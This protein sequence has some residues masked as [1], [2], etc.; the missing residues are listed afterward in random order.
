MVK[1]GALIG[2]ICV[3]FGVIF[4]IMVYGIVASGDATLTDF[5][6]ALSIG[7]N[8]VN[9]LV[10][11]SFLFFYFGVILVLSSGFVNGKL[12]LKIG[13]AI[14]I[15]GILNIML[16]YFTSNPYEI[17]FIIGSFL[18]MLGIILYFVGCIHFRK[19]NIV[20]L[21]TGFLLLLSVL[22]AQFI[23][24]IFS[25]TGEIPPLIWIRIHF[26]TLSIQAVIFTIH[27]W[28][29]GF[30]KKR[31]DYSDKVEDTLSVENGQAFASYVPD[32]MNKKKKKGKKPSEDDEI[33][34]TF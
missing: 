8:T 11:I 20:A 4:Q 16:A 32:N 27:S 14:M 3:T 34:F 9:V 30:S 5:R 13:G 18:M 17:Q 31:I 28:V 22:C 33:T 26:N 15:L 10:S 29:F 1:I 6:R 24:L 25:F 7:D 12:F 23:G 21:I 2:A 19:N